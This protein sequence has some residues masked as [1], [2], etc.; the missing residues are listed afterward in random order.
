[1]LGV[2]LLP[3]LVVGRV[4]VLVPRV[5]PQLLK[6]LLLQQLQLL[7]LL[8]QFLDLPAHPAVLEMRPQHLQRASLNR[9]AT[10]ARAHLR[11]Q[12]CFR[13]INPHPSPAGCAPAPA[14]HRPLRPSAASGCRA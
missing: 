4:V 2:G 7:Q 10:T 1:M 8:L 3:Q 5:V 13:D 12:Q 11:Q 9:A 6:V 14:A